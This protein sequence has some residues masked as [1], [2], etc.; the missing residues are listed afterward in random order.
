MINSV[1]TILASFLL[2]AFAASLAQAQ[3]APPIQ[4]VRVHW[5]ASQ[6]WPAREGIATNSLST[7]RD[8]GGS[9]IDVCTYEYGYGSPVS[10]ATLAGQSG[11]LVVS[12]P[13]IN[14]YTRQIV[15]YYR[16]W[17]FTGS[18]LTGGQFSYSVRSI[19]APRNVMGTWLYVL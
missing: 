17:R 5:V 9:W 13:D 18:R 14:P 3:P 15:G 1:R 11:V 19:N 7:Y 16:L 2:I 8:H 12:E 10:P 6:Q 4:A